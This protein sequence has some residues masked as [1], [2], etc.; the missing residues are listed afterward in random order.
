MRV[1][2]RARGARSN[3][4]LYSAMRADIAPWHSSHSRTSPTRSAIST[5]RTE[6]GVGLVPAARR[7]LQHAHARQDPG[8]V[9]IG[10][11]ALG[12]VERAARPPIGKP[13][14]G[15][16]AGQQREDDVARARARA[17]GP[18]GS[19]WLTARRLDQTS[20]ARF[21]AVEERVG[22][23]QLHARDLA[24]HL[25]PRG[26]VARR[27]FGSVWTHRNAICR[28][29]AARP[30]RAAAR[31]VLAEIAAARAP[32]ARGRRRGRR[33]GTSPPRARS[34]SCRDGTRSCRA[35]RGR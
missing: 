4:P 19:H 33:D 2:E 34:R 32:S 27:T 3:S 22:Q 7:Q 26:V 28:S 31:Y 10:P 21:S 11:G 17:S 1:L 13:L 24:R 16:G 15:H 9:E 5:A 18:A 23:P 20:G 25:A 30:R 8:A 6:P 29:A 35:R 14:Y 12:D